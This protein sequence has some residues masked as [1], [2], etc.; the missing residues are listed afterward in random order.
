M[1]ESELLTRAIA[2]QEE[3]KENIMQYVQ[4]GIYWLNSFGPDNTQIIDEPDEDARFFFTHPQETS[5]PV[6]GS[7]FRVPFTKIE[8]ERIITRLGQQCATCNKIQDLQ[9]HHVDENPA[10]NGL[11][12]LELLCYRCH[13]KIHA[14]KLKREIEF[15]KGD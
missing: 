7:K 11:D 15:D 3:R 10:N 4:N 6:I 5:R 9:I 14:A 2:E 1:E 8:R 13:K 12:N